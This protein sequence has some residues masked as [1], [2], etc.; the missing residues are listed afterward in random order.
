MTTPKCA[1][2]N[3]E[4][5]EKNDTKEHLI[6]NAIGGKKKVKGFICGSCN[7]ASGDNW[8]S[9][10]AKQLNPLSL[11]F[12][13]SR[14]RGEVPS[15]LFETTGGDKLKLNVDGSMDLEKPLYSES[16]LE[17][18]AGVRIQVRA[19]SIPEAERM[20]Q[21][22][23]RKYPQVDLNELLS[24]AKS[25]SSYCPDMLSFNF[26]FGGHEAG[27]SIVKSALA[28]AVSSGIP[29][30]K[31]T[32]A[33]HYLRNDKAEACFGYFYETDLIKNRP[34]G[35]P[36]HCVSI[37]GCSKTKQVIGYVEYFGVQR[38]VLCLAGSYEGE[39]ISNTYAINPVA[40][41]ELDLVVDLNLS[42]SEIRAAYDYK[43]IPNG[44]IEAA[45]H[46]VIPAG[47]KASFEK[48][49]D[50]VLNQAVMYAFENCG[51]K[52][53]EILMPEHVNKLIGLMMEKIE[54]FILHQFTQ[55]RRRK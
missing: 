48:E 51:V 17:S 24:N 54:P 19:R 30:E 41:E 26:S 27:R 15:Q 39:E 46:E 1:L 25:E 53:G 35:I 9:E 6:P 2:C 23:K 50:R 16:P 11:F 3:E 22:V 18:G 8:E 36:L 52:E 37:K 44:S 7:N 32:E 33:T 13:I 45:F 49:K 38:V 55:S 43:K 28:L 34:E 5:T 21:G 14:E 31:C 40:G 12:G 4:I 10:L 42:N 29:A 47:M 20:L